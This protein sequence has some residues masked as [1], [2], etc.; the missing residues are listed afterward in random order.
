MRWI[1]KVAA[2]VALVLFSA[3]QSLAGEVDYSNLKLYPPIDASNG[4]LLAQND[5]G[6]SHPVGMPTDTP[7]EEPMMTADK[8]HGYLG[9]ASFLAAIVAGA[10]APDNENPAMI[11]QP[12]PKG[13]HHYAGLTAAALGGAAVISGFLLHSED[14]EPNIMDPDTAHM[15][16]GVLS[17]A[18]YAYAVSKGPKKYGM[19][20]NK[21]AAAGI[22]GAGMMAFALY[23]EF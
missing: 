20:T 13:V 5:D 7:F 10:T 18:A 22:A 21:H 6:G 17:T 2:L 8:L 12:A 23:L 19:G 4:V 11:G 16:L 15:L 1:H 9:A 14:L 3:G